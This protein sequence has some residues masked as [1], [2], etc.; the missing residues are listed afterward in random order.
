MSDPQRP[1][2]PEQIR[3][4]PIGHVV[5]DVV[6]PVGA[7]TIAELRAQPVHIVI[8][9]AFSDALLGVEAGSDL[10]VI[11]FAHRASDDVLQVHPRGNRERPIR[12]VFATR[13][14]ARP[15]PIGVTTVQVRTVEGNVLEVVGLDAIDGTP[16]LDI[17]SHAPGF[18]TPY[19]RPTDEQ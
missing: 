1:E 12:G 4:R 15:N 10:L 3:M 5:R 11:F 18:D 9:P 6:E 19:A 17:K 8:D 16:V 13:S 7:D 14:P 2:Q